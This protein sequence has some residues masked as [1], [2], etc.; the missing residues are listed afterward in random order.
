MSRTWHVGTRAFL[1]VQR[2]ATSGAWCLAVAMLLV[3]QA[4]ALRGAQTAPNSAPKPSIARQPFGT[5]DGQP[6]DLFILSNARG[7]RA[8]ITNYGGIVVELW[9]P[10]RQ[11]RLAD[12]VLGYPTVQEYVKN[13]PYFGAIIGRYG[14]R[15]GKAR[16]VLGGKE[17]RLAAN[18][19]GNH[20]H[21][22]IKGF[23]KVIWN[24]QPALT[25][26][27]PELTL[28]YLSKDGEEG[29][30]G[31]LHVT[32]TYRLTR[33]NALD[34]QYHAT[35]DKPTPVNLTNHSY[36]NLRGQG[37]GDILGH[38]L[39]LCARQFTPVDAGL[40]PTGELRPVEG[41]PLDFRKS[42][43]I[44]K[45]IDQPDE[46]LRF[47][48]GYDHNFVLDKRP[49]ELGL[50]ARVVEPTTGRVM[51]VLTTEPGI[52]FYSG[53]FL[54]GTNVGKGGKVYRHRYGFCLET[55]HF[56]DSP[57]KPQFPSAILQPGQEYRSRTIYRFST[58]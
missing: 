57:N 42:V 46:Q 28:S 50:A 32:V 18:D 35:T 29:Y 7:M 10:D 44:G 43:A 39:M 24:A 27:G 23:D 37:E 14:N 31:N 13:S 54:D 25:S 4:P 58:K 26:E 3:G 51:E 38:E 19:H 6:V 48:R 33:D 34:I 49:G 12:V 53:N 47:G 9:V 36:F 2:G 20:L 40:I 17:Y 30:P 16:F 45:R 41:T 55:Q 5:V 21:G 8:A 15:I 22:G 1:P 52:Q 56:P 11:G